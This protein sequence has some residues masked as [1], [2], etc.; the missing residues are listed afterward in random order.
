MN[1]NISLYIRVFISLALIIILLYIMRGKYDQIL[2]ALRRT[3]LSWLSLAI[4]VYSAAI[5]LASGRLQLIAKVQSIRMTYPEAVSLN[6]IGY[7]FNNF[8]PTSI[9][10]DVAKAYHLSKRSSEKTGPY[11]SIFIDRAVGLV[12]MIFMAFAALLFTDRGA[13]DMPVKITICSITACSVIAMLFLMMEPVAVKFAPLLSLVK[14]VDKHLKKIY[15]AINS[16]RHHPVLMLETFAISILSQLLFFISMGIL[17]VGI[18]SRISIMDLLL[19][20]PMVSILS[21]L[22][23]I[24]GLGLREGATVLLFGPIMGKANAFAISILMIVMLLVTSL[25]GGLIYAL[26]PQFRVRLK[27]MEGY[28]R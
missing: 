1:K 21:L 15:R 13:I 5:M 23:S 8:L 14:P 2:C 4:L 10:G 12:T 16:Y 18:G 28:D 19:R 6:Y 20:M 26:S 22:P 24:N 3:N 17:A 27:D 7:F 11:T 25:A 9:G